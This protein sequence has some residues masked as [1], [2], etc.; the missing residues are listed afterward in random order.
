[1]ASEKTA[2][3]A[4]KIGDL[5]RDP[6]AMLPFCGYHM[7]D[8]FA[9]WV[10]MGE[11][12]GAKM[13]KIF[14]VNWFRKN[15]DGSSCG[16]AMPRTPRAEMDLRALR[17]HGEGD[18][19]P[20]RQAAGGRLARRQRAEGLARRLKELT[21]VDKEGWKAEL[22]LIKEHFATF[23]AKLPKALN[24]ELAALEKRLG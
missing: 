6:M 19:H 9:H 14:Y 5:R 24:D 16:R 10:K 17:R 15:G 20:D 18:R 13:P 8:Y 1:M 2:A 11:K 21:Q 7:G 3:A 23:G 12:G 4:G 22:P